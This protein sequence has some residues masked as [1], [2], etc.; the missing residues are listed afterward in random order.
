MSAVKARDA[1]RGYKGLA[2]HLRDA[3][4]VAEA[5]RLERQ[6]Q[7]WLAYAVALSQIPPGAIDPEGAP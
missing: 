5:N 4:A 7:W 1:A 2:D 3:G 6:S